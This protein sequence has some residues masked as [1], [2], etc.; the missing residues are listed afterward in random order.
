LPLIAAFTKTKIWEIAGT[1]TPGVIEE[2][3]SWATPT[4]FPWTKKL[5]VLAL[6]GKI[7][8][9]AENDGMK[10]MF[11]G[12]TERDNAAGPVKGVGDVNSTL[13]MEVAPT[14]AMLV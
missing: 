10:A 12:D 11:G 8:V 6:A 1:V 4:L 2:K 14:E 7:S 9:R 13:M 3:F 5:P